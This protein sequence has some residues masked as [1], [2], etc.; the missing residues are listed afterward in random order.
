M[1]DNVLCKT[2]MIKRSRR[3]RERERE[4]ER[5]IIWI[6]VYISM[7]VW[8][9]RCMYIY[10]LENTHK[11]FLTHKYMYMFMHT[12][13][14]TCDIVQRKRLRRMTTRRRKTILIMILMP[15]QKKTWLSKLTQVPFV[16]FW[17]ADFGEIVTL[18]WFVSRSGWILEKVG[19]IVF[20]YSKVSR[21]LTSDKFYI[22]WWECDCNWWE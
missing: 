8:I 3:K 20:L 22:D 19:F 9:Y 1:F 11:T 16:F 6:F 15:W 17:W 10:I 5:E 2:R 14:H 21:K 18:R 13:V 7:C 4:R 12:C